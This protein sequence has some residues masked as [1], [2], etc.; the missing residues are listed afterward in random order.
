[1]TSFKKLCGSCLSQGCCTDSSVPLVFS[2]DFDALKSIG[3]DGKEYVQEVDVKSK[4]VKAL[5]KKPNS[6]NC[7]FWD[8][9]KKQCTI[10][11]HR[12]FDCRAYPF[13]ILYL[14]DKFRWIVYSCNPHSNWEWS[15]KYLEILEKDMEK[16]KI[17]D[18]ITTFADNTDLILPNEA[19]KTPYVVLR[20]VK[21]PLISKI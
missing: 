20:E 15:E 9:I 4:K 10:Y 3:K 2:T 6:L 1:M 8:E 21:F 5:K 7:V 11:Q 17:F 12:P 13:D 19:K 18:E 16:N 14:D